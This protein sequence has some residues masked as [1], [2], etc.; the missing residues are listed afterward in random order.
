M[1]EED[2]PSVS[3]VGSRDGGE[4]VATEGLEG[5]GITSIEK[6]WIGSDFL[7]LSESLGR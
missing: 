4:R 6:G 1:A 5:G 2:F 3:T 7:E